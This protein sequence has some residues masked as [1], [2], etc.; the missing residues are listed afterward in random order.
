MRSTSISSMILSVSIWWKPR[1]SK[2]AL[3]LARKIAHAALNTIPRSLS[4]LIQLNMLESMTLLIRFNH[5]GME[6]QRNPQQI[7]WKQRGQIKWAT[8]G[9]HAAILEILRHKGPWE[10]ISLNAQL[11]R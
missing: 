11:F 7:Y 4:C 5:S 9:D 1:A 2:I 8:L 10:K 6:L 3:G